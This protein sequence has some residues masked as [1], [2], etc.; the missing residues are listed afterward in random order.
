MSAAIQEFLAVTVTCTQLLLVSW[1]QTNCSAGSRLED[2]FAF[3]WRN[4]ENVPR[5]D[6]TV[7]FSPILHGSEPKAADLA[8]VS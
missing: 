6:D 7:S 4:I 8:D 3:D 1:V 5:E 2:L